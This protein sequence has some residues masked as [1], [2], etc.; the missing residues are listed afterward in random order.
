MFLGKINAVVPIAV[1]FTLSATAFAQAPQHPPAAFSQT[2]TQ[3]G[4]HV[5]V[6]VDP[7]DHAKSSDGTVR[8]FEDVAVRVQMTDVTTGSPMPGASPAAWIDRRYTPTAPT[9]AQCAGE[10]KRFAEGSTFSHTQV[11]LTSFYVALLNSDPT[12]TVVDPRFGYGDTRLLAMVPL[13]GPGEDWALTANGDRLY[14]SIPSTGKVVVIDT[15]IWR[16]VSTVPDIPKAARTVLQPDQAYLWVAYDDGKNNSGVA[17]VDAV[18]LKVR[19]RIRTGRG[20]HH[21][22][23]TDDSSTA[24][25]T[26]PDDGTVSIINVRTLSKTADLSVGSKPGWIDYSSLAKEAY[27]SNEGDGKIVVIDGVT[28][29]IRGSMTAS[30]GLGQI[31]FAPGGRY[32]LA[33]NPVDDFIYVADAASNQII[34][35]G[36][37]DKGPDRISFTDKQAHIR[38]R[39]TDAVLMITLASLG[40]PGAE[41]SVADFSGGRHAPGAMLRFSPADSIVQ[42]S[43]DNAVL[44]AN[45]GDA[46]VYFYMEGAAAPMGNVSNYGHEPRAVLSID[47]NLREH[48]P[49]VYET[50]AKLPA[51][52]SYDFALFVDR[53]RIV[54][55]FDL[56]I[57]ADPALARVKPPRLNVEPRVASSSPVGQ[58]A[59]LAFRLTLADNGSPEAQAKDVV[60]LMMGSM[61]QRRDLA[62]YRGDGVY[63]VD[64]DVPTPGIYNVLLS[65]PS[66]GLNYTQYA[67]IQIQGNA[68]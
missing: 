24:F 1:A 49:G 15:G 21:M 55:C 25:V 51:E 61:W 2:I 40:Q 43:G 30:P 9:Q 60:I 4:A 18:T 16:I 58:S 28:G 66:L 8:E 22:A 48:A 56:P 31:R 46:S 12:I 26:N 45:P 42:A 65:S 44:V 41:I 33:V 20:Y 39:G 3:N 29:K 13:D 23:F 59:R 54:A 37:L 36:K 67:T 14:V 64:F 5:T 7:I 35:E 27:V 11:D 32:A 47:R 17:V 10:V 62:T 53:P 68:N 63:A 38:H 52:G 57:A 19:A 6:S 34:Q 50:T